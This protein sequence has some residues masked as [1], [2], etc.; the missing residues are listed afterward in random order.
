[1]SR[2]EFKVFYQIFAGRGFQLTNNIVK[3]VPNVGNLQN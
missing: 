2:R 1:M 3:M